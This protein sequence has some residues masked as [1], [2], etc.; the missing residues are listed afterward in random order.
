MQWQILGA[1]CATHSSYALLSMLLDAG[2]N[3]P[4][5]T[6]T[7]VVSACC[8]VSALLRAYSRAVNN[9]Q[10]TVHMLYWWAIMVLLRV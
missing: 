9:L 6:I 7:T 1:L 2:S 3:L 10:L 5:Q 4:L 8:S